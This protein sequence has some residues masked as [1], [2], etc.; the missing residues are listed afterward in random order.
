MKTRVI[1]LIAGALAGCAMDPASSAPRL[2]GPDTYLL[3]SGAP[4]R[5]QRHLAQLGEAIARAGDFCSTMNKRPEI[6][7]DGSG[8]QEKATFRCVAANP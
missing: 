5:A 8:N 6:S 4:G 2:V 1:V 7:V 3:W